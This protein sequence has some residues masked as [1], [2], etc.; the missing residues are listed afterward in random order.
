VTIALPV[1]PNTY[2]RAYKGARSNR[3]SIA[4]L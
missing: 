4:A 3:E 2:P 1:T